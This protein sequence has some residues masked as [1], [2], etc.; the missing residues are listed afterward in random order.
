[1]YTITSPSGPGNTRAADPKCSTPF[2]VPAAATA[3][4]VAREA[5]VTQVTVSRAF[6]GR[7]PVAEPTRRRIMEAAERLGYR[8]SQAARATRAGRTGLIGMIRGAHRACSVHVPEFDAGLDAALNERGLCLVRDTIPDADGLPRIVRERVVDGLIV[9]YVFGTP[10]AVREMIDRCHIPA[11]WINRRRDANCVRPDDEAGAYR[12]TQHLLAHGHARV[13]MI[14]Q[15]RSLEDL[16]FLEPHYSVADRRAGYERAMR[17]AGLA[18]RYDL[19]PRLRPHEMLPGYLAVA[20]GTYLGQ[21]N[22]PTAILCGNGQ[23]QT[24]VAA[25]WRLGLRVPDDLSVVTINNRA[26]SDDGIAVDRVLV[27]FGR[28]GREA[29]AEVEAV[30]AQP[31]RARPP[32]VIPL[33]FQRTGSVARPNTP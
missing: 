5:N 16:A 17:G 25:A 6:S 9:N 21:S 28:I 30:I 11:V 18:P 20:C 2:P 12:A 26:R 24:L 15:E 31:G 29:V 8:P 22:R 19:L 23:G 14:D 4:D 33:D 32:V 13:A 7:G 1:M 27:P 10:P 3:T